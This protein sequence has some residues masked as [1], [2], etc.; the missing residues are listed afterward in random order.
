M[1]IF[2]FSLKCLCIYRFM[3]AGGF[4]S[5]QMTLRRYGAHVFHVESSFC[6]FFFFFGLALENKS[7]P[8]LPCL[9]FGIFSPKHTGSL[10]ESCI[11][12]K[13]R[14]KLS[15]LLFKFFLL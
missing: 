6:D 10:V 15:S 12:Q 3:L 1:Q 7:H 2:H 14:L 13:I 5:T 8:Q 11:F 9:S 4:L